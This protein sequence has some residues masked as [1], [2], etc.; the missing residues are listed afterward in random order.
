MKPKDFVERLHAQPF[1]PFRLKLS[2]GQSFEVK[3][4]EQMMV[5]SHK[6]IL[7]IGGN[8]LGSFERDIH[9]SLLHVTSIED[10]QTA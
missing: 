8:E 4:P 3:H 10:T 5:F 6:I 7:G 2:D 1:R 9:C